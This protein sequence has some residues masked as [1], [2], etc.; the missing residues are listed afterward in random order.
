[1]KPFSF[2]ILFLLVLGFQPLQAQV[3]DDLTTRNNRARSAFQS[4]VQAYRLMDYDQAV[5]YFQRAIN[6][7]PEFIEAYILKAEVYYSDEQ[8][9]HSAAAYEQ[10]IRVDSLFFPSKHFYLG[11]ALLK[12]GQYQKARN[13]LNIFLELPG[14]SDSMRESAGKHLEQCAFAIDAQENPVPFEPVNP[15]SAINSEFAEY[16]PTLTADEQTLVF[17]RKKPRTDPALMSYGPEYEDFYVSHY[18]DGAWTEAENLGPPINTPGNEGAQSISADGRHLFYTACNRPEGVG[19]CDIYY[20]R[21]TGDRWST[22]S[23]MG[24]VVNSTSWDSQP[25]ISPDGRT[26]YFTSARSGS[27]GKMDIWKT[28]LDDSGNWQT[29]VNIGPAIN[30]S[31]R[32]MSPFIHP[33]NQTLFF[34]SDGHMGMGGLDI[35]YSRKQKDGSWGEPVNIGYPINTY[36]DEFSLVV[37]AKGD[38]AWFASDKFGGYGETDIYYFD[39]YEAARPDPVTYM[40]GIVYDKETGEK[41]RAFFELTDVELDEVIAMS[42]SDPETGSFLVSIPT[43]R[44]LALNVNK[45]GYL[46]FS[47]NFSYADERVGIDPYTRDIPLQPIKEGVAVVLRNIFFDT[48]QYELKPESKIELLR[49]AELMQ[50]NPEMK[51]E[52]SGH[53]DN[54]GAYEYN[55]ELSRNRARSVLEFLTEQGV[56]ENRLEYE[57]YADTRPIDTNETEEGRANNRRTEFEVLEYQNQ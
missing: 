25:S 30:T 9:E 29:P 7:D 31:G 34:A 57:G 55:L 50:E 48:D 42:V 4:G 37:G 21:R 47:E 56:E 26:L 39:L 19:S 45:T 22:P 13:R 44:N 54:V 6:H 20:A 52:I 49:L 40:R 2:F 46:F 15:G 5:Y 14:I 28:S 41:L 23:N 36:A 8:Y 27:Y 16:S 18:K 51:V 53:T 32:E 3:A 1:M 24:R 35:F 33:D 10:A 43:G 12:T 38:I 11:S 17:T